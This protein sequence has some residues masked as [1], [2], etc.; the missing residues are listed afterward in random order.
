[1]MRAFFWH[2]SHSPLSG[3]SIFVDMPRQLPALV[4]AT[5]SPRRRYTPRQKMAA[6]A[7][8]ARYL[9]EDGF[10][11]S[12]AARRANIAR[13][14]VEGWAKLTTIFNKLDR[15]AL[16]K[17]SS[18]HGPKS[19]LKSIKDELLLYVF[20][21]REA[22]MQVEY[23]LVLFKAASLSQSF[24]TKPFNTQWLAVKRVMKRHSYTYRMGTH[25][26]QRPPEEVA[27]EVRVW[28]DHTRPLVTGPH[29]N[30]RYVIN[31][32]QTPVFFSMNAKKSLELIGCKTIHVQKSP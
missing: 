31:M 1:M 13:S 11:W 4:G 10:C 32:D 3:N 12:E 29:C 5:K 26:S 25:E 28:M 15:R 19:Q 24:R 30:L 16:I 14:N 23:P 27:D 6:L 21:M 9:E 22:S 17:K 7:L 8:I 20:E 18:H 2:T